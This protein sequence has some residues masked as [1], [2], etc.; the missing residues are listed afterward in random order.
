MSLRLMTALVAG[1]A[2]SGC[3]G[4]N[5]FG[6]EPTCDD[7]P[8]AGDCTSTG[9]TD[10]GGTTTPGAIPEALAGNLE[11][12]SYDASAGTLTAVIDALDASPTTVTFV[13][14]AALDRPGFQA[15]TYQETLSNRIFLAMVGS[16]SDGAVTAGVSGSGQFT[17]MIWGST[18]EANTAFSK[19]VIGG[20][21]NYS[22]NYVGIQ[23]RG[24]TVPG[25]GAPFN[26]IRPYRVEGEV[27][28]NADF[29]NSKV[30]GG[31]RD[32]V[33]VETGAPQDNL[34]LQIAEIK[35]DGSF[36]G[37]VTYADL[38]SAGT[39]GGTFGGASATGVAGA[40]EVKP[41]PTD[42]DLLERGV[43]VADRCRPSDPS[44]CP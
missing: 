6:N 40:I 26:P 30:E 44:P 28:L 4:G 21:A 1:L 12:V 16:N 13:R 20:L 18:Y 38:Q 41:D 8:F 22:G 9:G 19:P 15:F 39:Y 3:S 7:P 32:R 42:S 2:V 37:T 14:N 5:P 33:V 34:F 17:K 43:F 23:N 11:S 36:A 29:T 31:I 27:L 25:P 35:P 24:V 10:G